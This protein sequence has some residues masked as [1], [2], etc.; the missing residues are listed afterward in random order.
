MKYLLLKFIVALSL[1]FINFSTAQVALTLQLDSGS[2]QNAVVW[3]LY[4]NTP[5]P[6]D[7][8]FQGS[9]WTL[10]GTPEVYRSLVQ[11][12]LSMIP[13][14]AIIDSAFLS[15]YGFVDAFN[16]HSNLSGPNQSTLQRITSAWDEN[17]VTWN[18]QPTTTPIDQVILPPSNFPGEDYLRNDIKTIVQFW[19]SNPSSNYGLFY[20]LQPEQ[21]Y[22]RMSFSSPAGVDSTKRPLVEIFYSVPDGINYSS[23]NNSEIFPNPFSNKLNVSVIGIQSEI[24]IYDLS[25]RKLL[26]QKFLNSACINTEKLAKGIYVY[27]IRKGNNVIKKGKAVKN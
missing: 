15:L 4:P 23:E 21:Y 18:T 10:M 25:S 17:T 1:L 26:Q 5:R 14:N 19:T 3:D 24:I 13:V 27:E 20:Q 8:L 11:F 9:A 2:S 12:D 6:N 22:R 16:G 7:I